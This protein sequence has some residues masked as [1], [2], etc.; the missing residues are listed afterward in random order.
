MDVCVADVDV[1][2]RGGR[3]GGAGGVDG[4]DVLE[5]SFYGGEGW[6]EKKC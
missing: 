6:R 2:D 5:F 4:S 3:D 1:A